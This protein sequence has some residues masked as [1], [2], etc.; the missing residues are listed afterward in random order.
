[1]ID[2]NALLHS[3]NRTNP[4]IARNA[5]LRSRNRTKSMSMVLRHSQEVHQ[6]Q[7]GHARIKDPVHGAA[8]QGSILHAA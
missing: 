4:M 1:M 2:R 3:R 7:A 6:G 5:L 8:E